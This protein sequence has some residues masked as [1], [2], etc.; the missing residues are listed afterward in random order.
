[1]AR[2]LLEFARTQNVSRIIIGRPRPR[3]FPAALFREAVAEEIIQRADDFEVTIISPEAEDGPRS[4]IVA[5]GLS[6]ERDPAAYLW[7]AGIVAVAGGVAF[8]IDRI[9]PVESL[10][11]V[12]LVAVLI[13]AIRHG[14]WPSIFAS[15][16]SFFAYNFFFTEPRLTFHIADRE[17]VLTLLLF[18]VV[19]ILTGNLASRLRAQAAAQRNVARRTANLYAFSRKI[20]AAASFDDIVWAAVHHVASTLQC[21]S[22]VLAPDEDGALAIAGGYPPEDRLDARDWGAARWA[23]EH[24]EAAG[25]S[26][27]TLPSSTWLFLPLKTAQGPQALLGVSFEEG[28]Q[29]LDAEDRRVL[30]ALVDQVAI[31]I[32]RARL[33]TDIEESRVLSETERLRAALLSSVSHDLRTPLVS[34]IGA[35]TSLIEAGDAVGRDG[36]MQLAETIRDEGERLNR[37]VQNLLDM[38]RISY[39]ALPL[40]KEWVEPRGLV[41]AGRAAVEG[42]A[43]RVQGQGRRAAD[44]AGDQGRPDRCI[45]QTLVNVLDNAAKYGPRGSEIVITAERS[46]EAIA[47]AIEDEGPGIPEADRERIFDMFYRV[48]AGDGDSKGTG[49]GLAIARGILDAHGGSIRALS[50]PDGRSGTRIEIRLPLSVAPKPGPETQK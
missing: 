38:T 7:A 27:E 16:L 45:E 26:S 42:R 30:D 46:G 33:T 18:L 41:G 37:Y 32:E 24:G 50:R 2:E 29:R 19:A 21:R 9:F 43:S 25:W 15:L 4:V 47:I 36:R 28:K 13:V 17:V 8:A 6:P 31:A 44:L 10:S 22:L 34:I 1:M 5:P 48:R 12:F 39:G 14:L 40:N 35:A 3:R 11:L 23:W 49:L 20:A